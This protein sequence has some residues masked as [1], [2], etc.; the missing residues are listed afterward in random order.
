VKL[1]ARQEE[2]RGVL[3][4]PARHV[5]LDG[6][7]RS[8]KT[9]LIT[10]NICVRAIKAARSRHAVLRFRFK[11]AK[12]AIGL[13]TLPAV[14]RMCFPEVPYHMNKSD[15]YVT[16][17]NNSEIWLGGLDEKERTENILG[18][19]FAT[20]Y[21]NECSQI[22][23]ASRNMA[24]TRLAQNCTQIT[25]GI[26]KPLAL[27]AYYDC[28]PPAKTHWV[29]ELF[30]K[31]YS[32]DSKS[33]LKDP[34]NY[35]ALKINPVDN[36]EN[37]P[38]D[39][40]KELEALPERLRKRF[41]R[42]EY[43]EAVP[44]A[45][46]TDEIIDRY[47]V[48]DGQPPQMLRIVI[49]IDP[50]GSGD[51]DN[52]DN[53]AIGMV[54]AGIGTDGNGYLLEDLTLKASPEIWGRLATTAYDRWR[55]N[56]I[57]GEVNYGGDMVRFVVQSA[58]PGVP[59]QKISASRGKAVRAEPIS[60]LTEQGKIRFVGTFPEL[61]DELCA[62]TTNG[63]VGND[64]PNRADAMVWAFSYLFPSITAAPKLPPLPMVKTGIM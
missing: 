11:H 3:N 63:Y 1:T 37:L 32:P 48:T 41:L 45:L 56:M 52:A 43:G 44:G 54:V 39:Y 30:Y 60:A 10:R 28:N 53:D 19:E 14:M 57:V 64:S 38:A 7:S 5:L 36:T 34:E 13:D 26:E 61:E 47:R 21:L 2:A 51:T 24:I 27:K 55:A 22:P 18:K 46:W 16:F 20:V 42:G 33:P 49:A 31:R 62:M 59:F 4:S 23:F 12:E 35:A 40:I 50:S 15:W 6:G 25:N 8:G 9:F 58:K 29:Y 17:P